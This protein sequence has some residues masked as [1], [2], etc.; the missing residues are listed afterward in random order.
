MDSSSLESDQLHWK[1]HNFSIFGTIFLAPIVFERY[2]FYSGCDYGYIPKFNA[3]MYQ[4]QFFK[5]KKH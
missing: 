1:L 5:F 3:H 4:V 2:H